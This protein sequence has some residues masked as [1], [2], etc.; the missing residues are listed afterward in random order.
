MGDRKPKEDIAAPLDNR[1]NEKQGCTKVDE[2]IITQANANADSAGLEAKRLAD[3]MMLDA[4]ELARKDDN[5]LKLSWRIFPPPTAGPRRAKKK[6]QKKKQRPPQ[7]S[8]EGAIHPATKDTEGDD[9]Q[10]DVPEKGKELWRQKQQQYQYTYPYREGDIVRML[11]PQ[12]K[13]QQSSNRDEGEPK[14]KIRKLSMDKYA[15]NNTEND[16]RGGEINSSTNQ[17]NYLV[18]DFARV[19]KISQKE[20]EG[21]GTWLQITRMSDD[22]SITLSPK[23][24][25]KLVCPELSL[26]YPPPPKRRACAVILVEETLPFRHVARLHLD[27]RNNPAGNIVLEIG[28]STGELSKLV[29]RNHL[30]GPRPKAGEVGGP[31]WIGMDHSQEMIDRCKEQLD[32]HKITNPWASS[33]AAKVVK[34]DALEEPK[35]AAKEATTPSEVFGPSPTVVLIDIGGNRECGPVVKTMKWVFDTFGWSDDLRM[36]IVKSRALVRQL[37]SDAHTNKIATERSTKNANS[38]V[39]ATKN[40]NDGIPTLDTST[41]MVSRGN[42]WFAVTHK[43]LLQTSKNRFEHRFKHPLKAPKVVSPVDGTT[44]ICRYHNYHKD[45]CKLFNDRQTL[46]TKCPLDH[47]YCHSCLR[48]GHVAKKCPNRETQSCY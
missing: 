15:E 36:V 42:E 29:W 41:G 4:E 2:V 38:D 37:Q 44:P 35:R 39:D 10:H 25:R 14:K 24:Q 23:E 26:R 48:K 22:K 16:S 30:E 32:Q 9:Q 19:D 8:K 13:E 34:V 18:P 21:H 7:G 40:A 20:D 12:K 3:K 17:N 45:G 5:A 31:A 33:Y 47:D 28:C 27:N 43:K 11:V 6:K 1:E 46:G